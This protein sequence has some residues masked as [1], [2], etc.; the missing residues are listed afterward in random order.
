MSQDYQEEYDTYKSY[1]YVRQMLHPGTRLSCTETPHWWNLDLAFPASP[2]EI[3]QSY[4]KPS[5]LV[6]PDIH[7]GTAQQANA[8][9]AFKLVNQ[10]YERLCDEELLA[11]AAEDCTEDLKGLGPNFCTDRYP[12]KEYTTKLVFK[13]GCKEIVVNLRKPVKMRDAPSLLESLYDRL[14]SISGKSDSSHGV[15]DQLA[16]QQMLALLC[17]GVCCIYFRRWISRSL[18]S[19]ITWTPWALA[20]IYYHS[21][22]T[23]NLL[24]WLHSWLLVYLIV[25]GFQS[26][27]VDRDPDGA[28]YFVIKRDT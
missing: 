5:R 20:N 23:V 26:V 11:I 10:A 1:R 8:S 22:A 13:D 15:S 6:H 4:R 9:M 19:L 25:M 7:Q 17:V 18:S 21:I 12:Y 2:L 16:M 27:R 24:F 3:K 14:S 28:I